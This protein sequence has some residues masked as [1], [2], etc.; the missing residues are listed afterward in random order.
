M[1]DRTEALLAEL[2]DLHRRQVAVAEQM[3]AGQKEALAGQRES[4]ETQKLAVERQKIALSRQRGGL[5]L[6]FILIAIVLAMIIVPWAYSWYRFLA[7][8]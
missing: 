1:S 2:V 8:R 4:I 6:V 5:R 7:M 3:L